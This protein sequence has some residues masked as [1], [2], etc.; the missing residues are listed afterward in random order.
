MYC[1]LIQNDSCCVGGCLLK[2]HDVCLSNYTCTYNLLLVATIGSLTL[3]QERML[4]VLVICLF[5]KGKNIKN[6]RWLF[7]LQRTCILIL[8][9][10]IIKLVLFVYNMY[11]FAIV[12]SYLSKEMLQNSNE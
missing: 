4:L 12:R 10:T 6:S 3:K 11:A 2:S 7:I 9:A 5:I 1:L 8:A